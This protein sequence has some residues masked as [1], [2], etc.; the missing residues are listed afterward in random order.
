MK[1]LFISS[2]FPSPLR[3]NNGAFNAVMIR[4]LAAEDEVKVVAPV[5]WPVAYRAYRDG[6]SAQEVTESGGVEVR[7]P[8]YFYTPKIF[9]GQSR[10]FFR[11]VDRAS[12]ERCPA[13]ISAAVGHGVLV[14]S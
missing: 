11:V 14:A 8:T 6:V 9:R 3:P 2:V 7:H 13:H 5:P 4:G 10:P 1:V 12:G